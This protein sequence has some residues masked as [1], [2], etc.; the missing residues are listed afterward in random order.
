M[1]DY[2]N[3]N[4]NFGLIYKVDYLKQIATITFNKP[5]IHNAL[6]LEMIQ[7]LS[8]YYQQVNKDSNIK[9]LIINANG[10]H[11]SSGADLNWM[12]NVQSC[13]KTNNTNKAKQQNLTDAKQLANMLLLLYNLSKP[14]LCAIQG[15]VYGGAL[16]II[17]C[18]DIVIASNN[19]QFCFSEVKLGLAPAIIS[20]FILNAISPHI[21]KYRILT[22]TPFSAKEAYEFGL[23]HEL[24]N[25]IDIPKRITWHINNIN[26]SGFEG[27]TSSKK[28]LNKFRPKISMKTLEPCIKMITKLRTS[29]EAQKLIKKFFKQL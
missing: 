5:E 14:V 7:Q 19:T 9:L 18:A 23:V 24:I 21:A 3:I 12:K 2:N 25:I 4:N 1:S 29:R 10:K 11:F 27:I 6:N 17:A 28:L 15:N 13:I 8:K 26:S 20:P 22:A 16:G